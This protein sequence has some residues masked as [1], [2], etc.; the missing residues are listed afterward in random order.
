MKLLKTT[1]E[2]RGYTEEEA[3]EFIKDFKAKAKEEGYTVGEAG[4]KYKAKKSKGEVIAEGWQIK[5]TKLHD[6]FWGDED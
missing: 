5:V 6:D 4:Y 1:T 3:Q 2:L